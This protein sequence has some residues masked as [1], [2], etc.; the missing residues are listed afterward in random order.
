M[1]VKFRGGLVVA[2]INGQ[3]VPYERRVIMKC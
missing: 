3:G 1:V 2:E